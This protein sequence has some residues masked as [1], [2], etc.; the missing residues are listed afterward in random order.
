MNA[1]C[2]FQVYLEFVHIVV[3]F[4]YVFRTQLWIRVIFFVN[5]F[6]I[7]RFSDYTRL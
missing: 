3:N 7:C 4:L 2:K 1:T 6:H 5:I